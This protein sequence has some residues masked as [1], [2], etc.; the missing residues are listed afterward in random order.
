MLQRHK[1]PSFTWRPAERTTDPQHP[2]TLWSKLL[3]VLAIWLVSRSLIV[4]IMQVI[5]P[6]LPLSPA[7]HAWHP[8]GFT[9]PYRPSPGWE[10]FTHW[11]GKWYELIAT[12]GY[13][14]GADYATKRYTISFPPLFS[15]VTYSVMSLFRLPFEIAGTLVNNAAF[16]GTLLLLFTWVEQ[17]Y[18]TKI[19]RWSTIAMAW[20]PYSLY[21]TVAYTEGLFLLLTMAALY[22]FDRKRYVWASVCGSLATVTRFFGT[23]LIPTLLLVAWR[24]R[25]GAIAYV[26]ALAM[27]LGWLCFLAYCGWRWGDPLAPFNA[28]IPWSE[29]QE[30]WRH[31]FAK[32]ILRRGFSFDT[33]L[34]I[35]MFFGGGYL[36]WSGRSRLSFTALAYSFCYVGVLFVSLSTCDIA[37]YSYGNCALSIA[38]GV[39]L[40]SRPRWRLPILALFLIK[41]VEIT[42][43]F[44]WW[45]TAM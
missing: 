6:L 10:L 37:R 42:I 22:A 39:L 23:A 15:I 34:K 16:L 30:T 26:S 31:V 19:A 18:S 3:F 21:G 43:R 14:Y 20:C 38:A 27:G 32:L 1:F 5:A 2:S 8:V 45:Y 13:E 25:R 33:I 7:E 29:G 40:A 41:L 11:D 4:V 9:F 35:V 24:Q 36:I 17:Q 44:T 28:Q 12:R